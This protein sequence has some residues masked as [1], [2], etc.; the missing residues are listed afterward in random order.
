MSLNYQSLEKL[1]SELEIFGRSHDQ[2]NMDRSHRMLNITRETGEFLNVLVQATNAKRILEIG[3]SNGY[4]TLW[5][6]QAAQAIDGHV[7][8]VEL[9]EY[10]IELAARNFARSGIS[11]FITQVEGNAKDLL[12]AK[13]D[14]SFDLLFLDSE[15]SDYLDWWPHIRRILRPGGLLVM[16][17]ALSH[18]EEVAAFI[19]LVSAD[20]A[21]S[22]CTVPVGKGEFLATDAG[23]LKTSLSTGV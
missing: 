19:L 21:Y 12:E 18:A 8:T 17:N 16:D 10:K 9:S 13:S 5:L 20:P 23:K 15:R 22:T 14:S 11:N 7:F 1:L 3:T 2:A 6:A 4:S